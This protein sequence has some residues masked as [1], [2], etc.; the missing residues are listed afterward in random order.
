MSDHFCSSVSTALIWCNA[1][2]RTS[3]H[4]HTQWY[5]ATQLH[6]GDI[7]YFPTFDYP[8][9]V[10]EGGTEEL[11]RGDRRKRAA[12]SL[13]HRL[14]PGG[15][16]YYLISDL[17]TGN[18]IRAFW[19]CEIAIDTVC[20][21]SMVPSGYPSTSLLIVIVT[22]YMNRVIKSTWNCVNEAVS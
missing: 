5:I 11:Q 9:G 8:T 7:A 4:S 6:D 1:Y 12:T 10:H 22:W 21:S 14:W 2:V 15:V 20:C 19:G 13:D 16:I 17:Y 18:L 3:F